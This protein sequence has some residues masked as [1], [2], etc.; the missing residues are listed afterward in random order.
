MLIEK[1]N[2]GKQKI[3]FY[4]KHILRNIIVKNNNSHFYKY[5]RFREDLPCL[6][7]IDIIYNKSFIAVISYFMSILNRISKVKLVTLSFF[8]NILGSGRTFS[9]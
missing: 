3:S 1:N 5:F 4:T 9:T 6:T 2:T 7:L 8:K